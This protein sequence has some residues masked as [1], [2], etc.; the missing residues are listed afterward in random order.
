MA[1]QP[2]LRDALAATRAPVVWDPHPRGPAAVPGVHLATPNESEVRELVP[3]LPGAS[4]L[5]TASRGAQ[6]SGGAGGPALSR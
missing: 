6:G 5:A 1:R 2:A 3:A 4:R